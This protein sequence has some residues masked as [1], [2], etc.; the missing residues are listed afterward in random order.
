MQTNRN[1]KNEMGG[2]MKKKIFS[3]ILMI[4]SICLMTLPYGVA[5]TFASGPTETVT[6]YFSYFSMMPFG[7]GNWMPFITIFLSTVVTTMLLL[8]RNLYNIISK[9]LILSIFGNLF[10]WLIFSSFSLVS[11]AI[12]VLHLL[13]LL[14]LSKNNFN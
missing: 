2:N 14:L 9:C 11:L 6:K 7:Y 8:K 3:I 12:V 10:A 1:L 5:T 13:V 4:T